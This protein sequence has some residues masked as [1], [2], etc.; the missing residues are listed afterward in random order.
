MCAPS[1]DCCRQGEEH[2]RVRPS[3]VN[4]QSRGWHSQD[5]KEN[6]LGKNSHPSNLKRFD[7]K[8]L[9]KRS[10]PSTIDLGDAVRS[11]LRD[12][13]SQVATMCR[14]NHFRNFE[15]S[16]Q[17][18]HF[19]NFEHSSHVAASVRKL[20]SRN[21][22]V[23]CSDGGGGLQRQ[24]SGEVDLVDLAGHSYGITSNPLTQFAVVFSAI[25]HDLDHPG[26]PNAQLVMEKTRNA[27]YITRRVSQSKTWSI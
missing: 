6:C 21:V 3:S 4:L 19:R 20:L 17:V 13:M 24:N 12:F 15:H 26:V 16:S 27:H 7:V 11:Q 14:G 2:H 5:D 23:D 8:E 25:I 22:S 9:E 1:A 18:R 10:D